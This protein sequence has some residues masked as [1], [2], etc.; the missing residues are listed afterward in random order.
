MVAVN[1]DGE[2]VDITFNW[3][4]KTGTVLFSYLSHAKK[5]SIKAEY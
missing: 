2:A 3:D 4:E 5:V 1:E